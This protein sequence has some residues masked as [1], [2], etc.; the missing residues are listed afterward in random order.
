M[1]NDGT[2]RGVGL[3]G[4]VHARCVVR[5]SCLAD[6]SRAIAACVV[7]PARPHAL[8]LF[9]PRLSRAEL[10]AFEDLLAEV[11]PGVAFV[12]EVERMRRLGMLC[13]GPRIDIVTKPDGTRGATCFCVVQAPPGPPS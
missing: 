2:L 1:L 3:M 11:M 5:T 12:V 10:D 6:L 8:L 9:L 13:A 4:V 7:E